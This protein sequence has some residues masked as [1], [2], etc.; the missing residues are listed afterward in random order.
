M[1]IG[2]ICQT[3]EGFKSDPINSYD[4]GIGIAKV[5]V[6][7]IPIV[8]GFVIACGIISGLKE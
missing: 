3:V 4:V 6:F 8:F 5:V 2:G 7:E 1:K